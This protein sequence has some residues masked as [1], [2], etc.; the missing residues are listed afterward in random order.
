MRTK[1]KIFTDWARHHIT[2]K[3]TN[4][5]VL[6]WVTPEFEDTTLDKLWGLTPVYTGQVIRRRSKTHENSK[7]HHGIDHIAA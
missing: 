6:R 5:K 1:D 4:H 2:D 7:H 3:T